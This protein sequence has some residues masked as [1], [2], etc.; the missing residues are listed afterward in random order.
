[1]KVNLIK[2]MIKKATLLVMVSSCFALQGQWRQLEKIVAEDRGVNNL[3]GS[4]VSVSGDYAIVGA[5]Q[6]SEDESGNNFLGA[7]GAAY[8]YKKDE[9]GNWSQIQKIVA[10]DRATSDRFGNSVAIYGDYAVVGAWF[11]NG[12]DLGGGTLLASGAAY[13]FKN[14]GSNNW[15][16]IKKLVSVPQAQNDFFGQSV[17]IHEDYVIVGSPGD[18]SFAGVA[19]LYKNDGSDNWTSAGQIKSSDISSGDRFGNAVAIHGDYVLVGAFEEEHSVGGGSTLSES[20]SAYIFK[21]SGSDTWFQTQKIVA[22]DRSSSDR[23]GRSV[24]I[25]GDYAIVGAA[26]KTI[27]D[28]SG[29][30]LTFAGAAYIFKKDDSDVWAEDK[31]LV[32]SDFNASDRFG[33]SVAISDTYAIVGAHLESEDESG[34]N[35]ISKSGSIY[36]F[37]NEGLNTWSQEAKM[38]VADRNEED[39]FGISVAM[40][41]RQVI[42]G[43]HQEDEDQSEENTIDDGGAAYF[44]QYKDPQSIA[45][46]APENKTYGD[47]FELPETSDAGLPITY[48]SENEALATIDGNTVSAIGTGTVDITASQ[49]GDDSYWEA[50]EVTQNLTIGKAEL[51]VTADDQSKT[52]GDPIPEL[53]YTYSGFRNNDNENHLTAEPDINTDAEI[54]SSVRSYA[55]TTSGGQSDN[56]D[57]NHVPGTLTIG[58]AMLTA[59]ASDISLNVGESFPATFS[60]DYAGFVLNEGPS[61]IDTQPTATPD[62]N[63]TSVPGTYTITVAGGQDSNYDFTYATGTLTVNEVLGLLKENAISVYPNPTTEFIHIG[64]SQVDVVEIY[65]MKGIRVLRSSQQKL[66]LSNLESGTYLIKLIGAKGKILSS[67][68]V[69]KQ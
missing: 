8:I 36:I 4:S 41:D 21:N 47:L 55:I 62:V 39:E 63:D 46:D 17:A 10:S 14:D 50:E 40:S 34:N 12:E 53:K 48:R 43:A 32:A 58:K 19:Y 51:T 52:Y 5:Y 54:A 66:N 45:F 15:M 31:K 65:N 30:S 68:K 3:F 26:N 64:D 27:V 44:F 22:S 57:F 2:K 18:D 56:Y 42:V 67:N 37:K 35:T 6:N 11:K 59:T 13:I 28:A 24:S 20:G 49:E 60:I 16:Q 33:W 1:M 61:I 69:V 38:T 29:G 25:S 9:S 23:F 7:S